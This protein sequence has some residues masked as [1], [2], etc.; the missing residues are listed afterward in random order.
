M[1]PW[2]LS[3]NGAILIYLILLSG[4]AAILVAWQMMPK[5]AVQISLIDLTGAKV[6]SYITTSTTDRLRY[7]LDDEMLRVF[8]NGEVH[9]HPLAN[10]RS[11]DIRP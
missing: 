3:E 9:I 7:K 2:R 6:Q 10:I 11:V 5:Q 1:P 4:V 8:F